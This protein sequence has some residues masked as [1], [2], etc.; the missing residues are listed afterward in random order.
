M[1]DAPWHVSPP[2]FAELPT[3]TNLFTAM[4]AYYQSPESLTLDRDGTSVKLEGARITPGFFELL[5]ARPLAGRTVFPGAGSPE[6]PEVL[7]VSYGMWQQQFAGAPNLVG[8]TITAQPARELFVGATL[9]RTLWSLQAAVLMVLLI[10]CANV[11]TL[12]V[13]R[14]C[15]RRGEFSVRVAIGAGRFRLVRQ[16]LIESLMLAA[17]AGLLGAFSQ[18]KIVFRARPLSWSTRNWPGAAGRFRIR[19]ENG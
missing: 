8:R 3:R 1:H 5:G 19:W 12:L 4:A 11:G 2:L 16:V 14:V 9:R 18:R 15:A 7:V 13:S 10:S 6:N 17:L